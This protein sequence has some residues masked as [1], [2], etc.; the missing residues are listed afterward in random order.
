MWKDGHKHLDKAVK[1]VCFMKRY[2]SRW[3]WGRQWQKWGW[4]NS[5]N[6]IAATNITEAF[7]PESNNPFLW[8]QG[9][10]T[11][12]D[13]IFPMQEASRK[14]YIS[15]VLTH[16]NRKYKIIEEKLSVPVSVVVSFRLFHLHFI[17]S[18]VIV[19]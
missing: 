14:K 11:E 15:N 4:F 16:F 8:R 18:F 10:Q 2:H 9:Q 1:L 3:Y 12:T 17:F 6:I 19:F 7:L 5:S 13:S